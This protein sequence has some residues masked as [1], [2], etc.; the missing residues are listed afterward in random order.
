LEE[1]RETRNMIAER[2]REDHVAARTILADIGN[3]TQQAHGERADAFARLAGLWAAHGDMMAAE[4]HPRLGATSAWPDP[5]AASL[6]LQRQVEEL[7]QDLAGRE[8]M[9]DPDWRTDYERLKEALERQAEI[10]Q[11]ELIGPLMDL[12]P[13]QLRAATEGADRRRR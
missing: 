12:P 9:P 7:A 5:V 3:S 6:E 8:A 10:E 2:I 13:D 11:M 4:V 1:K